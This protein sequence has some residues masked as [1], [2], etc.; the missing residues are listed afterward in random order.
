MESAQ[1]IFSEP[2]ALT[3]LW[4]SDYF[5]LHLSASAIASFLSLFAAASLSA[6]SLAESSHN[7]IE[8]LG[9]DFPGGVFV[10]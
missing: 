8:S 5:K 2:N 9:S 7:G 4:A 10:L 6:F 3:N 1:R